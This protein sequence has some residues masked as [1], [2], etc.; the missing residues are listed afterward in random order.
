MSPLV[1]PFNLAKFALKMGMR[2]APDA[3]RASR[4]LQHDFGTEV[5]HKADTVSAI[6]ALSRTN[7]L[8]EDMESV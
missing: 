4:H 2:I 6:R 5:D 3:E 8:V 1:N 7:G